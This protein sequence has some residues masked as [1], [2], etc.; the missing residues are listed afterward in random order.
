M[1]A[2]EKADG[3]SRKIGKRM[4]QENIEA[5]SRIKSAANRLS[6]LKC[7]YPRDFRSLS[8]P[9]SD[10]MFVRPDNEVLRIRYLQLC[11]ELNSRNKDF[12]VTPAERLLVK[13]LRSYSS[14]Y[15][16]RSV[17]IGSY[18][19]DIFIPN[20]RTDLSNTGWVMRGLA[21]EVDGDVHNYEPKMAK[22]ERK[23][24]ELLKL[25]I[26][27]THIHNWDFN[28]NAVQMLKVSY[29]DLKTQDSRERRR[30]WNRIYAYT[31]AI[32]LT[33]KEFFKIFILKPVQ[34]QH[35]V[36]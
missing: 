8:V 23:C 32:H 20:V 17:W 12:E 28:K 31:L 4:W 34:G 30:M 7:I 10:A 6:C 26:G 9:K 21:I 18:C 19:I 1:K 11:D 2:V 15:I 16:K 3:K 14:K 36:C 29:R 33:D 13:Q 27:L 25:G 35:Y 24:E 22:D 5:K